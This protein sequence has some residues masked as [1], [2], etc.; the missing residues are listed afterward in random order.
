M[1]RSREPSEVHGTEPSRSGLISI[2]PESQRDEIVDL[3]NELRNMKAELMGIKE[4]LMGIGE[5][6]KEEVNF[7]LAELIYQ[8]QHLS[9]SS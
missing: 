5:F 3:K 4:Y 1:K 8:F 2:N 7:N 9:I 6:L